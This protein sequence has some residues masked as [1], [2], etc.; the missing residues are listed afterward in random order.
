M[1]GNNHKSVWVTGTVA[2]IFLILL[3][4][5]LRL[6]KSSAMESFLGSATGQ[7][8]VIATDTPTSPWKSL[9]EVTPIAHTAP[10]PD[11]VP[12]VLDGTYTKLD[13]SSFPQWWL[14]RRCADYR[15]AGG[16]WKL[17][18][19]EGVVRIF[20][21]VTGWR[22]IASFT[23][24]GDRLLIFNDGYCPES[25]GEYS[26]RVEEGRIRLEEI[27][28]S[29][30]FGL[31]GRNL[32]MQP[33]TLCASGS[34]PAS[35]PEALQDKPGCEETIVTP[36]TP[37]PKDLQATVL[38]HGGDSRLFDTPPDLFVF[39]NTTDRSPPD[40]I[41][42]NSH[43][44]SIPNGL[45]R[46]L[47]WNGDWIEASFELPTTSVGVQFFGDPQIGW[48]RVLFDEQEVWRGNTSTIWSKLGRHGGYI[49]L[50]DF[51]PGS[52]T[53][54]VESLGFDYRPV[55]VLGF[56]FNYRG[57]VEP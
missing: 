49:E 55:T 28:D 38:V 25:A 37:P 42:I 26:W 52:H 33:W 17:Q 45:N 56:G 1:K 19:D 27:S 47:W 35:D 4:G 8:V 23:V 15:P 10:L 31:R 41:E 12:S 57:G 46:V 29:C 48:A 36:P 43:D 40:R 6:L 11:A 51:V 30:A 34:Q 14:C 9:L 5:A 3:V 53:I 7:P 54:R 39:A 32:S 50:S 24:S 20:Y 16:I 21:E 22:S 2:V 44:K 13:L 18:F